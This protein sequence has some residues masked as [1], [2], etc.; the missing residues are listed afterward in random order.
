MVGGQLARSIV[1]KSGYRGKSWVR[2][3][4]TVHRRSR[5]PSGKVVPSTVVGS[6]TV[7]CRT[8]VVVLGKAA[9]SIV[10]AGSLGKIAAV[11]AIVV[12]EGL[13]GPQTT[14]YWTTVVFSVRKRLPKCRVRCLP[15][16]SAA[17]A[18]RPP[19]PSG[20]T[21]ETQP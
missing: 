2:R 3:P 16:W 1:G 12:V 8:A 4:S 6:G 21:T 17:V 13:K 7:A 19:I 14:V 20:T 10:V 5:K 11:V 18:G 15:I 9:R